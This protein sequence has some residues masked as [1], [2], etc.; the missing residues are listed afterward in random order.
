MCVS[1]F[2]LEEDEFQL[3][4]HDQWAAYIMGLEDYLGEV[5]PTVLSTVSERQAEPEEIARAA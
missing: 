2:L 5:Q 4:R 1:G 3:P